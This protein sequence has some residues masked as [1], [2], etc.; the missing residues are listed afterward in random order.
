MPARGRPRTLA[1]GRA[2][3]GASIPIPT[4]AAMAPTPTSWMAGRVRP[5]A[6]KAMPTRAKMLP[7]TSR[8]PEDSVVSPSCSLMA[9]TGAMRT[10]RRAGLMAEIMVTPI[11]TMRA[12]IT[13]RDWKTSGPEGRVMPN[14]LSR[15]TSPSA[16]STPRPRPTSD[17]T[18]PRM[19]ASTNTE[20]NTWRRL[21]PTIRRRASSRVRCPTRIEKVLKM[22]N[23]PTNSEMKANTNNAVEK[24]PSAWL[25]LLV[26]SLATV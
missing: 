14:P 13:V 2:T 4:N 20:R 24:N 3:T 8:R 12:A 1:I 7:R 23:P 22:V 18:S 16:A 5:T 11:P 6:S 25:T 15:A 10:A 21:A 17:A 19:P 26:C 9:A